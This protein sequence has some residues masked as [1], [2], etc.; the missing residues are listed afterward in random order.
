MDFE[1]AGTVAAFAAALGQDDTLGA[2]PEPVRGTQ[3]GVVAGE[4]LRN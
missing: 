1:A 3:V 2:E 4:S